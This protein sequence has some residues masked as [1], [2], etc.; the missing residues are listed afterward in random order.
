MGQRHRCHRR[1]GRLLT[2][3]CFRKSGVSCRRQCARSCRGATHHVLPAERPAS[4]R[5]CKE[6]VTGRGACLAFWNGWATV[7]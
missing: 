4:A 2:E 6:D 7:A 5:V 3:E 1:A